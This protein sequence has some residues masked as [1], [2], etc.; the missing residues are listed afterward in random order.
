MCS[1]VLFFVFSAGNLYK[2]C[3]SRTHLLREAAASNTEIST[4]GGNTILA[5]AQPRPALVPAQP[6]PT[7]VDVR[8]KEDA[9]FILHLKVHKI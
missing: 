1:V 5:P 2:H 8:S 6:Q 7:V 3:K 9:H 4:T